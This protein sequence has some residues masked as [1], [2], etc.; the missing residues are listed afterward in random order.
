[1]RLPAP[2]LVP[3]LFML[4]LAASPAS[5]AKKTQFVSEADL[6]SS[7]VLAPG[8][9]PVVAGYPSGDGPRRDVCVSI[10]YVIGADGTP[11]EF[12]FLKAWDASQPAANLGVES[13]PTFA[14]MGS[15]VL[16][17]RRYAPAQSA[18]SP[19]PVFTA[20]SFGFAGSGALPEPEIRAH[21]QIDD[22]ETF[23]TE[24]RQ[25]DYK[26]G[27]MNKANLDRVLQQRSRNDEALRDQAQRNT[28]GR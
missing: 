20:A 10:G 7:W 18:S 23:V 2:L 4:V 22:L 1:M 13:V 5:A 27:T 8:V 25:D 11:S 19:R 15:A 9:R 17:M 12:T 14:R 16:G 3:L 26:R 28:R 6:P 24:H 21:C